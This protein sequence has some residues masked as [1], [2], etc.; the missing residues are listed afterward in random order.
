ML[1]EKAYRG[2]RMPLS[3]KRAI[4]LLFATAA[5]TGCGSPDRGKFSL[6]DMFGEATKRFEGGRYPDFVDEPKA[7]GRVDIQGDV[8]ESLTPPFPSRTRFEIDVPGAAFL[9]FSPAL[10]TVQDIRRARVEYRITVQGEGEEA[11]VYSEILRA[12]SA[13]EWHDRQ[14][15]LSHWEGGRVVLTLETRAVPPPETVPWAERVQ[16]GWGDPLLTERPWKVLGTRIDRIATD[17]LDWL[18]EQFDSSGVGPD[19][20]VMTLRFVVNLLIGGLLSL[21]IRELYK[22]FCSTLSNRENFANSLPLF[23]LATI[24]VIF[25]VQYSP[26]L[27]LG[28]VGALS[29]VRFRA[30]IASPEEIVYLLLC[31]GLGVALGASHL[32]LAVATVA[33]ATPFIILLPRLTRKDTYDNLTLTLSAETSRFFADDSPSIINI[34]KSMT[35]GMTVQ[36]LDYRSGR[37]FFK[38]RIAVENRNQV[39]ELLKTLRARAPRCQVSSLDS[40]VS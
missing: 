16:T 8:R 1:Q 38:A 34:I 20:Q 26:A 25:V 37:V 28:L 30:S 27:A 21:I 6:V 15:D 13:N 32:L 3:F 23:T 19:E 24:V 22:R 33:V 12:N 9:E 14:V 36:R 10:I 17:S 40:D 11:I 18:G 7:V 2:S 31:V 35:T 4:L 39:L 29:V 5:V